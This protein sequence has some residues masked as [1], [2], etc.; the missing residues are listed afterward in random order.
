MHF[1]LSN[2]TSVSGSC[3][4]GIMPNYKPTADLYINQMVCSNAKHFT[5]CHCSAKPIMLFF[6]TN[7]PHGTV[8][9]QIA[10]H[11]VMQT[12]VVL[13]KTF[14]TCHCCDPVNIV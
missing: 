9:Q 7:L 5:N 2:L 13:S 1:E 8:L 3:L 10:R 14:A 6:S 11:T 12:N 4:N